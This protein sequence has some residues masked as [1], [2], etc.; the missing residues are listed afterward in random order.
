[1]FEHWKAASGHDR[2]K[3]TKERRQKIAA[4]L[5]TYS[6]QELKA[7]ISHGCADPF[8]LGENDRGKRYDFIET[9]LKNDTAVDR[10]L[11]NGNGKATKRD[12]LMRTPEELERL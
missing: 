4:R 8:Y 7:A 11:N 5:K 2:S 9:L 10:H 3:L 1:M 12:P 6:V